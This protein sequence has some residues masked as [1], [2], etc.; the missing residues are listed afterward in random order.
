[1]STNHF[2]SRYVAPPYGLLPLQLLVR[3]YQPLE[4]SK[5]PSILFK[6]LISKYRNILFSHLHF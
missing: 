6:L 2:P 3:P 5:Q 4:A 1:M